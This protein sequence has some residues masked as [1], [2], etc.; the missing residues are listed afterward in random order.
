MKSITLKNPI[1][2][3]LHVRKGD[4]LAT[5]VPLAANQF[6]HAVIMPNTKPAIQTVEDV[7]R[8]KAE[9]LEHVPRENYF[10]PLMTFKILPE[11]D[12]KEVRRF[13]PESSAGSG[14]S[15]S[16]VIAGKVYPK[17][18][19]TN[20]EDGVDDYFALWPVFEKM[21]E[22]DIP[23]CIHGEMPGKDIEGLHREREFL[24]T[25]KLIV[26]SFPKLRVVMEHITT[27]AAV[28]AVLSLPA[29]VAAT[30]TAHHL[31]ITCDDVGVDRMNPHNYCKPVAKMRADRDALIYAATSG[32]PKFFF[33][34]DSAPHDKTSK[35][36]DGP[37]AGVFSAPILLP[38]LAQIFAEHNALDRLER[39]VCRNA[40]AF[41][42]ISRYVGL[43]DLLVTLMNSP[44]VVP[45]IIDGFVPFKAGQEL[46]WSIAK[47]EL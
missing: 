40:R 29:N 30:I 37:C 10:E 34:S 33:G 35:E 1:D 42:R 45:S 13:R 26:R 46:S 5:T 28:E 2:A 38:L 15:M 9:I 17:D 6:A 21:Q 22:L 24:R 44:M 7:R 3:H 12:P 4:T 23:L 47:N 18:L 11:T 8:Y 20:A 43:P 32:C 14:L 36:C 19:T 39:F 25:L 27:D 31:I 16:S 41:Y